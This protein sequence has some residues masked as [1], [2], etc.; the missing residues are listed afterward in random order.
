M[1]RIN[2]TLAMGAFCATMAF[3][4]LAQNVKVTPL[5]SIDGEFCP[6]DRAL[7]F[8]DPNGTRVLY[9]PGRTVAAQQT[10]VLI[11]SR[12]KPVLQILQRLRVQTLQC[13]RLG[14]VDQG[15]FILGQVHTVVAHR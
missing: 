9:D 14:L 5:G 4:A 13:V 6:Q 1:K 11:A 15:G 3:P 12:P 10:E 2:W 7:V 8:E